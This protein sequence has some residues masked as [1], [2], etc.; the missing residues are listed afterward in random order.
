MNFEPMNFVTNLQYM[1]LG[2]L[3]IFAV[4][5]V[6]IVV[7]VVLDKCTSKKK[8]TDGGENGNS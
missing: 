7:T 6:I 8:P 5:A 1:G 2:M 3:G 4:M